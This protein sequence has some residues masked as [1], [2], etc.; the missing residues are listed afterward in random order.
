MI[1]NST[2]LALSRK[3]QVQISYPSI[4]GPRMWFCSIQVCSYFWWPLNFLPPC[5]SK[6]VL[7]SSIY[8]EADENA[9]FQATCQTYWVTVSI[10]TKSQF[11]LI[12]EEHCLWMKLPGF[13]L[14]IHCA[15]FQ[16]WLLTLL[17]WSAITP[18]LLSLSLP[19]SFQKGLPPLLIWELF[20]NNSISCFEI[21]GSPIAGKIH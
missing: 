17:F 16:T 21:S 8:W 14:C 19:P 15:H 6:C 1:S 10:L 5:F 3:A 11:A 20:Q 12:F 7:V 9:E 4:T 2:V 13:S 18:L